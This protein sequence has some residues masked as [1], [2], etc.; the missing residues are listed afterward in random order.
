[1]Q[2]APAVAQGGRAVLQEPRRA[3]PG[4]RPWNGRNTGSALQ[5]ATGSLHNGPG[6]LQNG[7]GSLHNGPGSLQNATGSLHNG[8]GAL[9]NVRGPCA[10]SGDR[11]ERACARPTPVRRTR[12]SR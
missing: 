9:R 2:R 3:C 6:S 8:P 12:S 10:T 11:A 1:M 4:S 7:A 5:N